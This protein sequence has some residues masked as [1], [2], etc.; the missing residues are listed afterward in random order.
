VGENGE[1]DRGPT[2]VTTIR[3][4]VSGQ[5]AEAAPRWPRLR[6]WVPSRVVYPCH[7]SDPDSGCALVLRPQQRLPAEAEYS[8]GR[9]I[10]RCRAGPFGWNNP[11][12][13]ALIEPEVYLGTGFLL[14]GVQQYSNAR[15][16]AAIANQRT[17]MLDARNKSSS[18]TTLYYPSYIRTLSNP[19]FQNLIFSCRVKPT[20]LT[21][22]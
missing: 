3:L 9:C 16:F 19:C 2:T 1:P 12:H 6:Q 21:T 20:C 15:G 11:N 14:R 4:I 17:A 7:L 5:D 13:L 22:V 8:Y 18:R 10:R